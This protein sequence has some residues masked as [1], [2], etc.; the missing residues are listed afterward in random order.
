MAGPEP[1]HGNQTAQ[2]TLSTQEKNREK[3]RNG[4]GG[5]GKSGLMATLKQ[6]SE[7]KR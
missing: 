4:G 1:Q 6:R 5:G 3:E 7:E 2:A